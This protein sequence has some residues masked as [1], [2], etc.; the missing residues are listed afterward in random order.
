MDKKPPENGRN[1]AGKIAWE[2][3]QLVCHSLALIN[4]ELCLQLIDSGYEVTIIPGMEVDDIDPDSDPRFQKI[5]QR[6]RKTAFRQGRRPC[7]ASL[8]A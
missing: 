5:V 6:T 4:R 1:G 8:A 7:Q 3:T 2:G